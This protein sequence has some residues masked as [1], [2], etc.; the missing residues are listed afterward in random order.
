MNSDNSAR[1]IQPLTS[2]RF[3]AAMMVVLL[4]TGSAWAEAHQV[5]PRPIVTLLLNGFM[6]VT[7]FS[8]SPAFCFKVSIDLASAPPA[9]SANFLWRAWRASILF[10]YFHSSL[11]FPL[12]YHST[13]EGFRSF[14]WLSTGFQPSSA[15]SKIGTC[16]RG[17]FPARYSSTF[18]PAIAPRMKGISNIA[19]IALGG[20][21]LVWMVATWAPLVSINSTVPASWMRDIPVPVLRAPEF[22]LGVIVGELGARGI[23]SKIPP[24]LVVI[25]LVAVMCSTNSGYAA[26]VM[27]ISSALLCSFF[28]SGQASLTGRV[29]SL[30]VLVL[31]GGASYS[32]YLLHLPVHFTLEG[33]GHGSK[34]VMALQFPVLIAVGVAVFVFFEEPM[35]ERIRRVAHMRKSAQA[36]V[37]A[38]P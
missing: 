21:C 34:A 23:H 19:L 26:V 1:L 4:H 38:R 16:Q 28:A 12:S 9:V 36:E 20:G 14:S 31:L 32:I 11:S 8:C 33:F 25:A 3:F 24:S 22:I 18:F 7:F 27:A 15:D 17:P 5:V 10:T 35:R 13:P 29:L 2:M 30:R 37:L 6:G